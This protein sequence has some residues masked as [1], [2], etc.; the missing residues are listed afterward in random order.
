[1]IKHVLLQN[2]SSEKFVKKRMFNDQT[3][4]YQSIQ[5]PI[6][7]KRV[8]AEAIVRGTEETVEDFFDKYIGLFSKIIITGSSCKSVI[9]N[10]VEEVSPCF[11]N[12]F[13]CQPSEINAKISQVQSCKIT[14]PSKSEYFLGIGPVKKQRWKK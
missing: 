1:M 10:T 7:V 11:V 2:N 3:Q 13:H 4:T 12:E 14:T 6:H 5:L 9:H 8:P